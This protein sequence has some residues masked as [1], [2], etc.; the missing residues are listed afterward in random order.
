MPE[1]ELEAAIAARKE[2]GAE[3]E[4]ELVESFLSRIERELDKKIDERLEKQGAPR[5]EDHTM[6]IALG[7]IALGIGAT[8][9][10]NGMGSAGIVVA[11]MAWI[12]IA[13]VNIAH[14]LR[15]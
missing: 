1:G 13:I 14:A 3:R 11:V 4:E 8:A 2:L 6:R 9:V 12:A 5:K 10:A 7:S 15:P